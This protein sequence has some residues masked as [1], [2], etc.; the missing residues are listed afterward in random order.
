M[1]PIADALGVLNFED[2]PKGDYPQGLNL[3]FLYRS[4]PFH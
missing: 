3:A 2:V 1:R 4:S